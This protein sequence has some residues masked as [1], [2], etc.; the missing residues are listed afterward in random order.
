VLGSTTFAGLPLPI[1]LAGYFLLVL[2]PLVS[3]LAALAGVVLPEGLHLTWRRP[4][5]CLAYFHLL[6]RIADGERPRFWN[7]QP[8]TDG[9][10]NPASAGAGATFEALE[11][12]LAYYQALDAGSLPAAQQALD[13]ALRHRTGC[14]AT[15]RAT[16][17]HEAAY[18]SARVRKD[19]EAALAWLGEGD[20][21]GAGE[22]SALR[23]QAAILLA[24][25]RREAARDVAVAA[26]ERLDL[27]WERGLA[28][29]ER[30]WLR[31]ISLAAS[32]G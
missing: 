26:A 5:Q 9:A 10:A 17:A 14:G 21:Q 23:A 12:L 19:V 25:G 4:R 29:A 27:A 8:L 24:D 7:L 15:I 31:D 1:R 20:Q 2:T 11:S 16:L 32:A 30:D 3:L 28:A 13:R 18:F 6:G 22:R